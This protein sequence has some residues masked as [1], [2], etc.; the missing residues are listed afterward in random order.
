M[1]TKLLDYLTEAVAFIYVINTPN[2]GGVQDDRVI[3]YLLFVGD[4]CLQVWCTLWKYYL[5]NRRSFFTTVLK[6]LHNIRRAWCYHKKHWTN[7]NGSK[8]SKILNIKAV[9]L[10]VCTRNS[11]KLPNSLICVYFTLLHDLDM[12]LCTCT[13]IKFKVKTGE[14]IL[15]IL[16]LTA[17]IPQT[18]ILH[19]LCTLL[20]HSWPEIWGQNLSGVL[21]NFKR[22]YAI[23]HNDTAYFYCVGRI[24]QWLS[25]DQFF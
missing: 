8:K 7:C 19:L 24:M 10:G 5:R 18:S 3:T 9:G 17:V 14:H 2:A 25:R 15:F 4:T 21:Y 6:H 20:P 12:A 13:W 11:L 16:L 1:T 23:L 22:Q